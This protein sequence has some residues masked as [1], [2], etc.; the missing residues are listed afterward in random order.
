MGEPGG[1]EQFAVG[2]Q[3]Q[4]LRPHAGEFNQGSSRGDELVDRGLDT[5]SA[6][7]NG[8][9]CGNEII[10]AQSAREKKETVSDQNL[11]A[12][13]VNGFTR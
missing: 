13:T 11:N 3:G 2:A 5:M 4:R 12:E 6:T 7:A 10:R 9:G 1:D 8:F